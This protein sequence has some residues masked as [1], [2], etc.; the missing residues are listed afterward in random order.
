MIVRIL[1]FYYCPPSSAAVQ[2]FESM[3]MPMVY[4]V[5]LL[6]LLAVATS[7]RAAGE[8]VNW[9]VIIVDSKAV[10]SALIS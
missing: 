1:W 3:K 10:S 8:W 7:S 2:G 6:L 9:T 5:T 4:L